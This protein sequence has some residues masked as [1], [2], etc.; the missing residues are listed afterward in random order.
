MDLIARMKVWGAAL[1]V[2]LVAG[3]GIAGTAAAAAKDEDAVKARVAEFIDVFN[4]GDAKA[5]AAFWLEDGS[6]VNPAGISG[7]GPAEIE[8]VVASDISQFLKGAQMEM[9]VVSYRPVGKDAAWIDI[10]HVVTGAKTPDGKALPPQTFHVPCLMVKKGKTWM[11]AEARP[12]AFLPP[13][14]TPTQAKK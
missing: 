3:A 14:K 13:P 9:K 8:K 5:V 7:K 4:K 10:E 2:A 1:V 12:Y 6:L 11:I